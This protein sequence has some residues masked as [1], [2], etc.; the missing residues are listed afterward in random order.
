MREVLDRGRQASDAGQMAE[1]GAVFR[2]AY[3]LEPWAFA[4]SCYVHCLR[5]QRPERVRA[6]AFVV[7]FFAAG[8]G[9]PIRPQK[10]EGGTR[11]D[12][13]QREKAGG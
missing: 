8:L 3:D 6:A 7:G 2:Q 1:A 11:S 5:R 10:P 4:A 12:C 13:G 9:W